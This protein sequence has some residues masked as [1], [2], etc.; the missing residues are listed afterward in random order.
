MTFASDRRNFA[1]VSEKT[2]TASLRMCV[3]VFA[4]L[5]VF[6]FS[7]TAASHM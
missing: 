3:I 1:A 2:E 4:A 6:V 7:L 5:A